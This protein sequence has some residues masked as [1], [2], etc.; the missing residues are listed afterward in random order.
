MAKPKK[1]ACDDTENRKQPKI[2]K[3]DLLWAYFCIRMINE[4]MSNPATREKLKAAHQDTPA[5]MFELA[6]LSTALA[7]PPAESEKSPK[8]GL[9]A[10]DAGKK[11]SVGGAGAPGAAARPGA[12]PGKTAGPPAGK[13][14]PA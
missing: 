4:V 3:E 6:V 13:T 2:N 12:T 5:N 14:P 9:K 1:C 10:A 8:P 11:G 7:S